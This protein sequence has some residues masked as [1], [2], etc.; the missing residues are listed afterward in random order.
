MDQQSAKQ[1]VVE[2]IKAANHILITV[3]KDPTVDQLAACIGMTLMLNK[4]DKH[5]TAVF[6][7]HVPSTIEFLK[8]EETINPTTDSLRDFIISLDKN[9]A[10][11]LRYKVENDVVRIF[12]TPYRTAINQADLV[13]TQGDFNVEAV[14]ALGITNREQID[15]AI[16]MHGRILHDA[17]VITVNPGQTTTDVGQIN[18][19]EQGASS[20]SEMLMSVSEA[21]GSGLIDNQ[22]AT[23][24]LTGI[25]AETDRFA[26]DKTSPKV[27]T[28]S[29]QLMAAGANQQLIADKLE[30][31]D[32]IS[33]APLKIDRG[34][35]TPPTDKQ[36]EED[37][38]TLK[39]NHGEEPPPPP[40]PPPP[41]EPQP[42]DEIQIDEQ[43]AFIQRQD[44]IPEE[45]K[46]QK[47]KQT[48][49]RLNEPSF[50]AP[51][52]EE[53]P[54]GA[55]SKRGNPHPMLSPGGE[56]LLGGTMNA[57]SR[58]QYEEPTLDPMNQESDE[59]MLEH[60]EDENEPMAELPEPMTEASQPPAW[61]KPDE[62]VINNE[63]LSQIEAEV[64]G[65]AASPYANN[66]PA[67]TPSE[68]TTAENAQP[69][70]PE[71]P[72]L[73]PQPAPPEPQ[74]PLPDPNPP[75]PAEPIAE[76]VAV[77]PPPVEATVP[78]LPAQ[79]Q[80]QQTAEL[81]SNLDTARSAVDQAINS[82]P[83]DA[84]AAGPINALNSL[85]LAD[86]INRIESENLGMSAHELEK[87]QAAD[88]MAP[89]VVNPAGGGSPDPFPLG[90]PPSPPPVP[91]P[92]MPGVL[93]Q[94]SNDD[95][96]A[97][98]DRPHL[99]PPHDPHNPGGTQPTVI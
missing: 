64:R 82:A 62:A 37:K 7:G 14:I 22:I 12:I 93:P 79:P 76:P 69:S 54:K 60:P 6:S 36:S 98:N 10:D 88:A 28:M 56:P 32:E 48:T 63:T 89:Q 13:F 31:A 83:F 29:A 40:P 24:F 86:A 77:S 94:P 67:T 8:P 97:E 50:K 46:P 90:A 66:V 85:P 16:A 68:P 42:E 27:M 59:P 95:I 72:E 45:P 21:F 38:S 49:P 2:K 81:P 9:K 55:P 52:K 34:E 61:T 19:N 99:N 57:H 51:T 25:V 80:E 96:S 47:Q 33:Q 71:V 87:K 91:P 78:N 43:G 18:W 39:V 5:A 73:P 3:S 70:L 30:E 84:A 75:V 4:M 11:K 53:I 26:N 44:R 17:T 35:A 65:Y 74:M 58:H 1:Q 23:A 15:N 92:F 20:L 41:P